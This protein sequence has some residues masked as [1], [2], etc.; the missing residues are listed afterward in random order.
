MSK[1]TR[2]I[3]IVVA[4]VVALGVASVPFVLKA[5]KGD[6]ADVTTT[7]AEITEDPWTYSYW[8][9]PEPSTDDIFSDIM[10]EIAPS[11]NLQQSPF[12]TASTTAPTATTTL[13]GGS[14][15]STTRPGSS[16]SATTKPTTT[17]TTKPSSTTT[18][19]PTT[20]QKVPD[21]MEVVNYQDALADSAVVSYLWN[22]EGNFYFVEDN[23][24]QRNFGFNL[25][26]DWASPL[27]MMFYDTFRAKF[28][29][30]H[31]GCPVQG[32]EWMIQAWKGQYGFLFVGS[33]IGI[34]TR[35]PGGTGTH[36]NCADDNHLINM[37]MTLYQDMKG[38]KKEYT[39]LFTR[40]YY[41][42]WWSTG[43]VDG[44]LTNYKFNDRSCLCVTARFTM[45]DNEMASLFAQ[46]LTKLKAPAFRQVMSKDQL[47][48]GGTDS[49]YVDGKDVYIC[50][51]KLDEG[52]SQDSVNKSQAKQ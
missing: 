44:H 38:D 33:E 14:T 45:Y 18:A 3:I 19:P 31:A 15:T 48:V 8:Q 13:P 6:T 27:T 43:F 22:P 37:E 47:V 26:Y 35:N 32:E 25:L 36:Y 46:A 20:T 12:S 7:A 34:Y 17:A 28:T 29:Y 42:H 5:I 1:A 52:T 51:T 24:W 39:K 40:S 49:F 2:N 41:P 21:N 30:T 50:W 10:S 4:V 16:T 9:P 23:P 11:D